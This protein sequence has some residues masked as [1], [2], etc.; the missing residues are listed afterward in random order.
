MFHSKV[1]G[2]PLVWSPSQPTL[3]NRT[4]DHILLPRQR[5]ELLHIDPLVPAIRRPNT[6]LGWNVGSPEIVAT[7]A[8]VFPKLPPRRSIGNSK[9]LIAIITSSSSL[10]IVCL[11]LGRF[12]IGLLHGILLLRIIRVLSLVVVTPVLLP[13]KRGRPPP[14]SEG[15]PY[16]PLPASTGYRRVDDGEG[17]N[18]DDIFRGAAVASS[19]RRI[20]ISTAKWSTR[21]SPRQPTLPPLSAPTVGRG[22]EGGRLVGQIGQVGRHPTCGCCCCSRGSRARTS[23]QRHMAIAYSV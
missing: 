7:S 9:S 5:R 3:Q 4:I 8:E 18:G 23:M 17:E 1:F 21:T 2:A 6:M 13:Q 12:S 19:R 14:P 20:G 16:R 10:Q 11:R 22:G 15:R